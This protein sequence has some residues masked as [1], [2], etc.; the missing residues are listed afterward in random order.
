MRAGNNKKM[1]A[2]LWKGNV[3]KNKL[4]FWGE[5]NIFLRSWHLMYI[6][7]ETRTNLANLS[8]FL[9]SSATVLVFLTSWKVSKVLTVF[10]FFLCMN[11]SKKG[12]AEIWRRQFS[13]S[14]FQLRCIRLEI[15]DITGCCT[16]RIKTVS[17]TKMIV[18]FLNSVCRAL[19]LLRS[20]PTESNF[21]NR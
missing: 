2:T 12:K 7:V 16:L 4:V 9:D 15:A 17:S 10:T 1:F 8:V 11:S 14:Q 21:G 5:K 13:F 19:T 3:G 6:H 18:C 20:L